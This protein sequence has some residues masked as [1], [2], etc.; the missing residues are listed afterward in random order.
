[1][2]AGVAVGKAELLWRVRRQVVVQPQGMEQLWVRI[3]TGEPGR[4]LSE[5]CE[6]DTTRDFLFA[7]LFQFT[8]R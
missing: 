5:G 6:K 3:R 1:M 2:R 4:L 7:I 8:V